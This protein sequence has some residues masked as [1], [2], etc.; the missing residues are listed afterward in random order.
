GNV[1]E[2]GRRSERTGD[3]EVGDD[4]ARARLAGEH[5][6]R[7]TAADEVL[8]HLRGDDLG[9]GAHALGDDAVVGGEGEDDRT[10]DARRTAVHGGEPYRDLLQP[11]ETPR[12]L[13]ERIEV[14]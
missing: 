8:D 5:V 14:R 10:R 3:A 1:H 12:S 11:P 13:R 7:R 9:I 4:D 2:P 6:D